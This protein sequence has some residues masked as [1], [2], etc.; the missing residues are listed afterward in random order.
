[1]IGSVNAIRAGI[2]AASAHSLSPLLH[3]YWLKKY[4]INGTYDPIAV[5]PNDFPA[6]FRSLQ[7]Q[8]FSGANVTLPHKMAAFECVDTLDDVARRIGAV[9]TVIVKDDGT[10]HG[11][12]TDAYGFIENIVEVQPTWVAEAGPAVVLGAGGAARAVCALLKTLVH[13]KSGS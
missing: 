12:N 9:N 11:S 13:L 5:R 2:M 1:M 8:G 7:A 10:L 4:G 3:R 6:M